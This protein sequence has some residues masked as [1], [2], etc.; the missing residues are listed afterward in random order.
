MV[1]GKPAE[2][3]VLSPTQFWWCL[4]PFK[5]FCED[6]LTADFCTSLA[7]LSSVHF[8]R[9]Y[10]VQHGW[11]VERK[12]VVTVHDGAWNDIWAFDT[13]VLLFKESNQTF[14][15]L[16]FLPG[17]ES[18]YAPR[19]AWTCSNTFSFLTTFVIQTH[20]LPKRACLFEQ[21]M[22]E[23]DFTKSNYLRLLAWE[24][25]VALSDTGIV[26]QDTAWNQTC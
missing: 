2:S 6:S 11:Q 16:T 23:R 3:C 10:Y 21:I 20:M 18:V 5:R 19:L 22:K 8:W 17:I 12:T 26:S 13:I 7:S 14:I 4:P 9:N 15:S 25:F 1:Q 24:R